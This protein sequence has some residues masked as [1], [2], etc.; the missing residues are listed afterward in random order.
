MGRVSSV[1]DV[2]NKK[3]SE[4][5]IFQYHITDYLYKYLVFINSLVLLHNY[6]CNLISIGPL[7]H[8]R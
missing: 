2:E 4:I 1:T 8:I 5:E 7:S 6:M 3:V